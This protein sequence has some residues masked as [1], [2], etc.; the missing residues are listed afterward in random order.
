MGIAQ[1]V[2][3][4]LSNRG[5]SYDLVQHAPTRDSVATAR[6]CGVPQEKLAKGILIRRRDG[7]FLAVIP[8]SRH[9]HLQELGA[10]LGQ[11]VTLASETDV[12][13]I[14]SDC[15]PGSVPPVAGAYGLPGVIDE[16]LEGFDHIYFEA[17]DHRTLVHVSGREFRRLTADVPHAPISASVH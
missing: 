4:F 11:P 8:A 17:G 2:Q 9:V 14:F 7:Y 10:W 1:S 5:V 6:A 12:A 13:K 3:H 15:A 16:S